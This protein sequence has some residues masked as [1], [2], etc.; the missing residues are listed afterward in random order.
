VLT[1]LAMRT[2]IEGSGPTLPPPLAADRPSGRLAEERSCA[3][4]R[5]GLLRAAR[6]HR[7]GGGRVFV[8][9]ISGTQHH[10]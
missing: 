7:H 6:P 2:A 3:A 10:Q 8:Y 5:L 9:R 1:R 4:G